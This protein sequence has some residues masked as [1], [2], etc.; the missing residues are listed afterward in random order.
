MPIWIIYNIYN[1]Y[2]QKENN[3]SDNVLKSKEEEH[4]SVNLGKIHL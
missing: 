1:I 4:A 3:E 2:K